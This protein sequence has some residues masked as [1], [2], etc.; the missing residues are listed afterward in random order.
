ME[1]IL[2][3]DSPDEVRRKITQLKEN[4]YSLVVL[5]YVI[6]EVIEGLDVAQDMS[7]E[8]I[9]TIVFNTMMKKLSDKEGGA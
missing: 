7:P 2:P 9:D 1:N 8:Q 5:F 4:A 3:D 6:R